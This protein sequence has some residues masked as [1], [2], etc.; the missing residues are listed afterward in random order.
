MEAAAVCTNGEL[1]IGVRSLCTKKAQGV[2]GS[3]PATVPWKGR[4]REG[5]S[6]T[7]L[8]LPNGPQDSAHREEG[9]AG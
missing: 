2:G 4:G 3:S 5:V 1:F 8:D 6:G 9:R 7:S